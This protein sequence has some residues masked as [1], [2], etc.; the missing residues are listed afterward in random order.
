MSIWI[1]L[2][3]SSHAR[4][5]TPFPLFQKNGCGRR[6]LFND[7]L[8]SHQGKAHQTQQIIIAIRLPYFSS[9]GTVRLATFWI[10]H[11]PG[12]TILDLTDLCWNLF[13]CNPILLIDTPLLCQRS[14]SLGENRGRFLASLFLS[15]VSLGIIYVIIIVYFRN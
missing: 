9:S 10:P 13:A 4:Y 15:A 2:F 3:E 7:D 1:T 5:Y 6:S 12:E 8:H 14:R 11:T